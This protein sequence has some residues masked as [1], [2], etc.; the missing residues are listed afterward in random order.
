MATTVNGGALSFAIKAVDGVTT[1]LRR[2]N[3]SAQ[4]LQNTFSYMGRDVSR[5]GG[6]AAR[7]SGLTVVAGAAR[8]VARSMAQII[9][10]LGALTAAG[11]MAG[12]VHMASR[13]AA[14]GTQ[15][16]HTA[17]RVQ[18]SAAGLLAM[19]GA[20]RL[21]GASA[22]DMTSGMEGLGDAL[23]DAVGGRDGT[24]LQYFQLLGVA[25]RDAEGKARSA[26]EA[27][28]E[29]ADG[30]A[31]ISDPRLQ[32]RVMSA[33]RLPAS[34]LPFLKQGS[35][36][37]RAWEADARRFGLVTEQGAEAA[38]KFE[39]AQTHLQMAGEGLVNTIAQRLA[40]VISPLLER[41]ANWI[42]ANREII[43]QK[44][45]EIVTKL[46]GAVE[47]FVS[48]GGLQKIGDGILSICRS[49]ESAV[50]WMGGWERTTVALG[51]VLTVSLLTPLTGIVAALGLI[52]AFK[53]PVWMLRAL[54]VGGTGAAAAGYGLLR[55]RNSLRDN[56]VEALEQKQRESGQPVAPNSLAAL[57]DRIQNWVSTNT[58]PGGAGIAA[59]VAN[60]LRR[61]LS[62]G[63]RAYTQEEATGRQR[64]A[65]DFFREK[66]WTAA[67]AAGVVANLRHESGA[68]LDH[69]AQ[70]DGGRAFGLAQW[71]PDRQQA[72][73]LWAGKPIQQA[74]FQEQLGFVHHELTEGR[75]RAAGE[76][77]RGTRTAAE[78]GAVVS[79]R[80][81]R[82]ANT[83][84]E[85]VARAR[86]AAAMLP[87]LAMPAPAPA[88][89]ANPAAA[90]APATAPTPAATAAPPAAPANAPA[91]Q[92]DVR[93]RLEG[94][95][96]G[97]RAT[98][99]TRADG[100]VRVERAMAGGL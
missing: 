98:T 25:M 66:G 96:P 49:V 32:A 60:A 14:F 69:Q 92:V 20:A 15:L 48:D 47:R 44:V 95:P 35:A 91:Q 30:I 84:A 65:Y 63:A 55:M 23:S 89:A 34:L 8:N 59:G 11:S 2:I 37:L 7:F 45:E 13:W 77:L 38:K 6:F 28:P 26:S 16:S 93:V 9:P 40:P 56:A 68:G 52:G 33:L 73:R 88:Q 76:A 43:G 29:V 100:G 82:P 39:L 85:A 74:S 67:Q 22:E 1:P 94:L 46:A 17:Y 64:E 72:F 86:T 51:S 5:F 54:G 53:A 61:N 71:H 81:E 19:Q 87:R 78:A 12:V 10:P 75:E 42:A 36:G 99:T 83:E 97:T 79:R 27:L 70:G 4:K 18:T 90:P 31:R 41:L 62:P 50:R 21:A 57:G 58:G 3:D 24:A 80:Y